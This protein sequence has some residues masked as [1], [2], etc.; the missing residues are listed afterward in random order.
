MGV[1]LLRRSLSKVYILRLPTFHD[2]RLFEPWLDYLWLLSLKSV[3]RGLLENMRTPSWALL[4]G[5]SMFW[6][7]D[8]PWES[9]EIYWVETR[10]R[11]LMVL[12]KLLISSSSTI[13]SGLGVC[14]MRFRSLSFCSIAFFYSRRESSSFYYLSLSS[15]LNS[16]TLGYLL[17]SLSSLFFLL[18]W[19]YLMLRA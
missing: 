6:F 13:F 15:T 9:I 11:N 17:L 16:L 7:G 12:S 10:L 2:P 8:S 18:S 3:W 19:L 1:F 4:V 5:V 14:F